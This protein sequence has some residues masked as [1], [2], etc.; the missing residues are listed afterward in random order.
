MKKIITITIILLITLGI[1]TLRA[2]CWSQPIVTWTGDCVYPDDK[3]AY[4]VNLT[5]WDECTTPYQI[6][7]NQSQALSTNNT[8]YTFCIPNQLC[9]VDQKDP[10]FKMIYT[11]AK[12]N[13]DTQDIVCRKQLNVYSNCEG[14]LY[15]LTPVLVLE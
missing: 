6:I 1:N 3:T 2:Q 12:V 5:I 8:S 11:V 7:F 10:C 4:F 15:P 9:T 13:I 14:I